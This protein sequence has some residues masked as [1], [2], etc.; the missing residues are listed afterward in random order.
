MYVLLLLCLFFDHL[1]SQHLTVMS[2]YLLFIVLLVHG[3]LAACPSASYRDSYT[4]LPSAPVFP[5][6]TLS[7]SLTPVP[8]TSNPLTQNHWSETANLAA[9]RAPTFT[10]VANPSQTNCPHLQS[11]LKDWHNPATWG[12][13]VPA[14]GAAVTIPAN[15]AVLVSSCSVETSF[16][17]G[18]ITVPATS[19]LIFGDAAISFKATGFNVAGSLLVGSETCRLRNKVNIT[20]YGS[21]SAQA[22]PADPWV[23]GIAVNGVID[24]HGARY[25]PTWTRLALTGLFFH[26]TF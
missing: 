7:S 25:F 18:L 8:S 10:P 21:R 19:K 1:I 2:A 6:A 24:I 9:Y 4:S 16:V 22:L 5:T 11:G 15:T 12:G 26:Y 3:G 23:K 20:L 14:N 13:S 17:F